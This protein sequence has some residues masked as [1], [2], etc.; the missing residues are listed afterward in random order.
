[1]ADYISTLTG[2]QMDA[3]LI[4]MAEHTSEAYAVGERNGVPVDSGDVTYHNN[5]RYYASQAQSIAPASVTEAVRWDVAQTALTDAQREQAREN[6]KAT[7]YNYNLLDNSWF[8][9]NSRGESS[10]TGA[11]YNF[12]RWRCAGGTPTFTKLSNY[13]MN[14]TTTGA[15][16]IEQVLRLNKTD[17]VGKNYTVSILTD[18]GVYSAT[19]A[20]TTGSYSPALVYGNIT[21]GLGVFNDA[22]RPFVRLA[23]NSSGTNTNIYAVKLELGSFSTL[24][25]DTPPDYGE[26]LTRCIYSTADPTDTYA[27]NGFGRTNP[28]LL[29]NPWWG[30]GEVVNQRNVTTGN[31]TNAKY[32]IDRWIT[33]YGTT[34]GT[35]TLTSGGITIT[36]ATGTTGIVYQRFENAATQNGKTMTASIMLS[37]G[38]IYSGT[39]NR[40]NGTLQAYYNANGI[41]LRQ[42]GGNSFQIIV[43]TAKTI[44]AV[45]LELGSVSTLANDVPPDYGTELAK[46]Q[47][48]FRRI[49][50]SSVNA[51]DIAF[52][53]STTRADIINAGHSRP[54]RTIP[55]VAY[56]GAINVY[57]NGA[58]HAVTAIAAVGYN[59][60]FNLAFTTSGLSTG[61]GAVSFISLN[62]T[63][64][65]SADL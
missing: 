16:N 46:C 40:T 56:S 12:D 60:G 43:S 39:I 27:N 64:D 24:A 37:D 29:D 45:K 51:I 55:T 7:P 34:I 36:P 54:M 6:I 42:D 62:G 10:Y 23:A 32:F 5:A 53:S 19:G 49:S 65:L 47:Y 41:T 33:S 63:I 14:Y 50:S 38:T 59:T 22:E 2:S 35:Y 8:L 4:D 25:N 13:G 28:N 3:A 48:Y 26:E 15:A 52:A 44:R 18:S 9:V 17:V 58:N 20:A 1:M 11:G 31:L 30:S 61:T 57:N 21:I